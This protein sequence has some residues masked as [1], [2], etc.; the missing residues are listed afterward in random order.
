MAPTATAKKKATSSSSS[1]KKQGTL[2]S[3]FKKKQTPSTK[4]SSS[5]S[6]SVSKPAPKQQ[7]Q[8]TTATLVTSIIDQVTVGCNIAVY[9]PDDGECGFCFLVFELVSKSMYAYTHSR[10]CLDALLSVC[11]C[12]NAIMICTHTQMNITRLE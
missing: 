4:P 2:F 9:W 12:M 11:K 6:Q 3:F 7:E 8:P 1:G 5:Q 10:I